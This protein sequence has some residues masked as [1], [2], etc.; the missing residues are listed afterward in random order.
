MLGLSLRDERGAVSIVVA[1][2]MIPLMGF[3]AL[4]V[5]VA[6]LYAERQ[7]LQ[8]GADAAALA[9]AQDCGRGDCRTPSSTATDL[10][11]RNVND[12]I[13]AATVA[14]AGLTPASTEVSVTTS[15]TV[16]HYFAPVLGFDAT[17][18]TARGTAGWGAP[19]GGTAALPLTF[20]WCNFKA[21]TGG[22]V[23][24]TTTEVIIYNKG[25]D[26]PSSTD[27]NGPFGNAVPGGFGWL[28]PDAGGCRTTTSIALTVS[29][30]TGNS[31]PCSAAALAAT[32]NQTVL[33]PIF[34]QASDSGSNATYRIYGYAAF[35][36]TGYDFAG[37]YKE[38]SPC[39]GD[40]RC[41][42]G[43]F[44]RFVALDEGFTYGPSAPA[45]GVSIVYLKP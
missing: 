38:N 34:D 6:A 36:V 25:S 1:L 24:S 31:V 16:R 15:A 18:V 41:I 20:S 14:P 29:S 45:L 13:A 10:A 26:E 44:T 28:V 19:T 39:K 32:L 43:Y 23:P 12:G 30:S 42:R 4:A 21:Q 33:L 9:I 2:L 11:K 3:A 35:V 5:D 40:E 7:Q 27:C 22:G 17:Q 8:T 37:Q